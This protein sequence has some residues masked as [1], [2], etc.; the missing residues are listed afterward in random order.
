MADNSYLK[1]RFD[2]MKRRSILKGS[3]AGM[4][5]RIILIMALLL[6]GKMFCNWAVNESVNYDKD[7]YTCNK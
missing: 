1:K 7:D 6:F 3:S 2:A 4:I 5:L